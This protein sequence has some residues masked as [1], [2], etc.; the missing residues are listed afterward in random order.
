MSVQVDFLTLL[1]LVVMKNIS[2]E[3]VE[4]YKD[5]KYSLLQNNQKLTIKA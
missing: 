3:K 5:N 4:K 1:A 2:I